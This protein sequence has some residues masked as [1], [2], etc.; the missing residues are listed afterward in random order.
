MQRRTTVMSQVRGPRPVLQ[1]TQY[2]FPESGLGS[3]PTALQGPRIRTHLSWDMMR[4]CVRV[5]GQDLVLRNRPW[6]DHK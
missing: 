3:Q 2:V 1:A 4:D 5:P 6:G